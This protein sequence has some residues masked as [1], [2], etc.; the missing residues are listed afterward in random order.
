MQNLPLSFKSPLGK[1]Y[2]FPMGRA[3][4]HML[5]LLGT[6]SPH[7]CHSAILA[8]A[9]DYEANEA[10]FP[11]DYFLHALSGG[12]PLKAV[13]RFIL[14]ESSTVEALSLIL[15][16]SSNDFYCTSGEFEENPI[17]LAQVELLDNYATLLE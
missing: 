1:E 12:S 16:M 15:Y 17:N 5:R 11:E 9:G 10:L 6:F 14:M 8:M 7:L 4:E 3:L 13:P 2:I